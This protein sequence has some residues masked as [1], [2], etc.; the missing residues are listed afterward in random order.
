MKCY[1]TA[2]QQYTKLANTNREDTKYLKLSF[3]IYIKKKHPSFDV[4]RITT[5][6]QTS[7]S[8]IITSGERGLLAELLTLMGRC[9]SILVGIS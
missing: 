5:V 8:F 7:K 9:L 2:H 6:I 3:L 4:L 1:V